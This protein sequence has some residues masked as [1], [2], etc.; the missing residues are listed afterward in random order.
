MGKIKS[1]WRSGLSVEVLNCLMRICIEG[2]A[3]AEFDPQP[4]LNLC[5]SSGS[6]MRCPLFLTT[7]VK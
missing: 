4:G 2:P 1:D 6:R 7:K 3:I 5:W